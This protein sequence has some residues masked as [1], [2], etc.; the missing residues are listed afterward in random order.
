MFRH[1]SQLLNNFVP[2][3]DEWKVK[4]FNNWDKV[5]G[6][7]SE[8]VV[9]LKVERNFLLLGVTHPALAHEMFMLSDILKEKINSLFDRERIK[10]IRFQIVKKQ[11]NFFVQKDNLFIDKSNDAQIK[12]NLN[13]N[14]IEYSNLSKVK[15]IELKSLLKDFYLKSKRENYGK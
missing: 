15:D 2:A 5:L 10:Y 11:Q 1:I 8:K 9:I 7:L 13:L 12:K 4:L 14:S 3:N 6:N